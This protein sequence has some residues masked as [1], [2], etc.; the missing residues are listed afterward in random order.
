MET[1]SDSYEVKIA[2]TRQSE[3]PSRI[4]KSMGE[5]ID[6]FS[7]IDQDLLYTFDARIDTTL[8]LDDIEKSS[9]KSILRTTLKAVDDEALKDGD[10]KKV[11]GRFLLQGKYRLLQFLEDKKE[12]TDR[13]QVLELEQELTRLAEITDVKRI[14]SYSPIPIRVLLYDIGHITGA[15]DYL[16]PGDSSFYIFGQSQVRLNQDFIFNRE[17]V[18]DLLT[19]ET[20][21]SREDISVQVKKPDYLGAS[22][23]DIKFREHVVPAKIDDRV[24]LER[25][26][27]R[28]E[29]VRPGDGLLVTLE[30]QIS[31]G[32]QNEEVAIHYRVLKIHKIVPAPPY[33]KQLDL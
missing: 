30:T 7:R 16:A 13:G 25:F 1:Q 8:L 10:W 26:Q 5:L 27:N 2:F 31:Y 18:E 29:D 20:K 11:V 24:W 32:F 9:L 6:A 17:A 33:G 22:M 19:K 28:V 14:P 23:W 3:N 21:V 15:L 4:F 12:I